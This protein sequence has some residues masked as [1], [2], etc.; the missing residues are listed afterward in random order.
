MTRIICEEATRE[1]RKFKKGLVISY[2]ICIRH[3]RASKYH[4]KKPLKCPLQRSL[5]SSS[6]PSLDSQRKTPHPHL[7][8]SL[9]NSTLNNT[10]SP[11]SHQTQKS[12]RQTIPNSKETKTRRGDYQ[13]DAERKE[14]DI[15]LLEP[16]SLDSNFVFF[17]GYSIGY[18]KLLSLFQKSVSAER[19]S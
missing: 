8:N 1:R 9:P 3:Q 15:A 19:R 7:E 13:G 12:W 6:S 18:N 17:Q 5:E 11:N 16:K 2:T 14:R 4:T 10:H